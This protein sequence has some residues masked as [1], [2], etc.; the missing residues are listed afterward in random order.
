MIYKNSSMISRSSS[1]NRTSSVYEEYTRD[2]FDVVKDLGKGAYG[3]VLLVNHRNTD[4]LFA[5]K[6]LE[7]AKIQ[8][9]DKTTAVFRER[10]IM[11]EISDHDNMIKLECTFNDDQN[12]YFLCDYVEK[13]ALSSIIKKIKLP[14]D[15]ARF[16]IAE[17]V[18]ALEYLHNKN[19]IHRDL[20]PDNILLDSKYHVKICD[21]GE[22]KELEEPIDK[23]KLLSDIEAEKNR[24]D[25]GQEQTNKGAAAYYGTFVGTPYY[26][27]PEMLSVSFSGPFTDL[28]SLGVIIYELV[29]GKRPWKKTSEFMLMNEIQA[30]EIEYPD[31]MPADAKD[32]IQKLLTVNPLKRIGYGEASEGLDFAA[33][34]M[35]PF[36]NGLNFEDVKEWKIEPPVA[37]M[38]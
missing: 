10:D 26:V 15:T 25:D 22:A 27:P 1:I 8:K 38:V 21:F 29:V 30:C 35:H 14:L 3:T 19:I 12:L 16:F 18:V 37:E 7:I 11:D 33:L 20:K 28:W 32:L 36:F 17:V 9:F 5:L 4:T 24:E 13:G 6:E 23:S 31:T 34:K 2:S